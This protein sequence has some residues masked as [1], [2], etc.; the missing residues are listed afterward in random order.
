MCVCVMLMIF[1]YPTQVACVFLIA[2][3]GSDEEEKQVKDLAI[4]TGLVKPS[5]ESPV[6]AIP[7][8]VSHPPIV[9]FP[10]MA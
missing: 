4:S 5:N 2:C 1:C 10:T 3:V 7:E 8:H 6:I 9:V